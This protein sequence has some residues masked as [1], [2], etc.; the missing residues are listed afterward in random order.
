MLAPVVVTQ[1]PFSVCHGVELRLFQDAQDDRDRDDQDE[2]ERG[3]HAVQLLRVVDRE[4]RRIRRPVMTRTVATRA[5][6]TRAVA[7]RRKR[8][9]RRWRW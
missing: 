3:R 2:P 9:W 7:E 6:V 4:A 1:V 8:W 5:A